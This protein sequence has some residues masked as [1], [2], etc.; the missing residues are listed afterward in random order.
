MLAT[1]EE[2]EKEKRNNEAV[3]LGLNGVFQRPFV[4]VRQAEVRVSLSVRS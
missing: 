2:D 4:S 3:M 1:A